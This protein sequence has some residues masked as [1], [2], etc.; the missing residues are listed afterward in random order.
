[1]ALA[2]DM[3][4]QVITY[5]DSSL[6]YLLNLNC[7]IS[8]ANT[9]FLNFQDKEAN[10]G[11]TVSFDLPPRY[12][13]NDSLVATFQSSQQR[14][15]N[16]TVDKSKN[17]SYDFSNQQFIFNVRDYM[18]KF[19]KSAVHQLSATVESDVASL[20]ETTPYRFYGDGTTLINSYGQLAQILANY[21]DYGSPP[22][23]IKVYLPSVAVPAIINTGANQFTP[24]R[25][26]KAVMSW[27][28]GDFDN[29]S[30]YRSNFLPLHV[31][32]SVGIA[33]STLTVVSTNDPTGV[34]ISQITF[35]GAAASDAAAILE[36]DS[37]QFS[38]GVSG[39]PDLRFL[40]FIGYKVSA[41]PVQVRATA[42][43]G[44]NGGGQVT[45]T[46]TP[47]LCSQV[48]NANQNILYNI[49]AGM[50]V[51]VLPSHRCGFVVGGNAMY[52]AMPKLP[53]EVPYP[54]ANKYDPD[55]G[56]SMRMYYGS[57][58]AMNQRGFVNDVIWGKTAVP[59]YVFKIAFPI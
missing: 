16:L 57:Q 12:V 49:V 53:D 42:T 7:F 54:T 56:V 6:K 24:E 25:T 33:G 37:L 29:A 59:E 43:S 52:L 27:M 22:G 10:L 11:S 34:A 19:G 51:T 26:N 8:T 2:N 30:F 46:I 4:Q 32:G 41:Q 58:F 44:S 17:V 36:N 28:I 31:A 1:M 5:Q 13:T 9:K 20:A 55:T 15:Q 45:V 3:L 14:V 50:Q 18:E 47:P 40:T 35:S 38:D 23:E 48:G 21:R 39:Q